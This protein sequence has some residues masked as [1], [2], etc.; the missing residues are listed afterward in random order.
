VYAGVGDTIPLGAFM[1]KGITMKTGQ[2]HVH[3]YLRPLLEEIANGRIDPTV[4]I[5]H[6]LPLE[7]AAHAYDIF[8]TKEDQC[9]KVVLQP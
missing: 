8:A 1:E 6:R 9:I 3:R 5:S 7:D 4:I 2:T